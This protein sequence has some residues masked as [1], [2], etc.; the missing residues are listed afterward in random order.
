[1]S[2]DAA[3][4]SEIR[5]REHYRGG[6]MRTDTS[7]VWQT[8]EEQLRQVCREQRTRIADLELENADLRRQLGEREHIRAVIR[9][10][11]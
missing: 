7:G 5:A 6:G 4:R 1:M 10:G 3:P 9:R 2:K 11:A 8:A